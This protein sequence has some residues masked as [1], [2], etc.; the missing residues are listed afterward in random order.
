MTISSYH[1]PFLFGTLQA[2]S[3]D[4]GSLYESTAME[5][6]E[7]AESPPGGDMEGGGAPRR[8]V[9]EAEYKYT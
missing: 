7:E 9:R 4:C 5:D 3:F 1:S 6:V 8:A 2:L